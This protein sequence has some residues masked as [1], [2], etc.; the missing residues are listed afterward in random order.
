MVC[1]WLPGWYAVCESDGVNHFVNLFVRII[2]NNFA[3][4]CTS[5]IGLQYLAYLVS[6]LFL[7]IS[8]TVM[9]RHFVGYIWKDNN[10][11]KI[12]CIAYIKHSGILVS[13]PFDHPSLVA[14]S[15]LRDCRAVSISS[16][17]I[18]WSSTSTRWLPVTSDSRVNFSASDSPFVWKC[19]LK[20]L[21][22]GLFFPGMCPNVP[23]HLILF[24]RA[25]ECI[26]CM[27]FTNNSWRNPVKW[28]KTSNYFLCRV[29]KVN[30]FL[31]VSSHLTQQ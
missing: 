28:I 4:K 26:P 14:L 15:C 1:R 24:H 2:S 21:R 9:V 7:N 3:N 22:V 17:D 30:I 16:K 20:P 25:L 23:L 27:S 5:E 6:P 18:S 31:S 11:L 13:I 12:I 29:F 10:V 19:P 8:L